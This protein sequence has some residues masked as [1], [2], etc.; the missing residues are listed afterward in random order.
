VVL[1]CESRDWTGQNYGKGRPGFV[2]LE[3]PVGSSH[4]RVSSSTLTLVETLIV[5]LLFSALKGIIRRT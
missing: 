4:F 5:I 2:S 3:V 1:L